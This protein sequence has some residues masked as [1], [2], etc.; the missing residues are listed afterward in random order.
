M[1]TERIPFRIWDFAILTFFYILVQ[2]FMVRNVFRNRTSCHISAIFFFIQKANIFSWGVQIFFRKTVF[3][4]PG[5]KII[6]FP[7]AVCFRKSHR[8]SRYALKDTCVILVCLFN[9][10]INVTNLVLRSN[11]LGVSM[12]CIFTNLIIWS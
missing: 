10:K 5:C 3:I 12:F 9:K 4:Y 11:L 8:V 1:L 6:L 2:K 7:P